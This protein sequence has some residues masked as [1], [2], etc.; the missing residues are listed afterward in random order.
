MSTRYD[1]NDVVEELDQISPKEL[2]ISRTSSLASSEEFLVGLKATMFRMTSG[3]PD[4]LIGLLKIGSDRILSLAADAAEALL[5]LDSLLGTAKV[6]P[7]TMDQSAIESI[8]DL[9]ESTKEGTYTRRTRALDEI[10]IQI[11]NLIQ[12]AERSGSFELFAKDPSEVRATILADL[13]VIED[14]LETIVPLQSS[15]IGLLSSNFNSGG[16]T[17]AVEDQADLIVR[18]LQDYSDKG[19]LNV[20]RSIIAAGVGLALMEE[21]VSVRNPLLPKYQ[22][23]VSVNDGAPAKLVSELSVPN[24]TGSS[25]VQNMEVDGIAGIIDAKPSLPPVMRVVPFTSYEV[26][27]GNHASLFTYAAGGKIKMV[28]DNTVLSGVAA[29]ITDLSDLATEIEDLDPVNISTSVVGDI[30]EIT[31]LNSYSNASRIA[32]FNSSS[33]GGGET[34]INVDFGLTFDR[35]GN[36]QGTD[37]EDIEVT[38]FTNNPIVEVEQTVFHRRE[39]D[40]PGL[41]G[42]KTTL[43]VPSS[44]SKPFNMVEVFPDD[45]N[46]IPGAKYYIEDDSGGVI[47]LDQEI[48]RPFD[49][50]TLSA[51]TS[52][53]VTFTVFKDAIAVSSPSAVYGETSVEVFSPNNFKFEALISTGVHDT[54]TLQDTLAEGSPVR[55]GD[56]IVDNTTIEALLGAVAGISGNSIVLQIFDT[57]LSTDDIKIYALGSFTYRGLAASFTDLVVE[58][59]TLPGVVDFRNKVGVV[60]SSGT[61]RYLVSEIV[62]KYLSFLTNIQVTHSQFSASIPSSLT[63]FLKRLAE[64]RLTVVQ[65]KLEDLDLT[66]FYALTTAELSDTETLTRLMDEMSDTLGGTEEIIEVYEDRTI[67]DRDFVP[68]TE[69]FEYPNNEEEIE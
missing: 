69:I 46:G 38:V 11:D 23:V 30:I 65:R 59:E 7:S 68:D 50:V 13:N 34:D 15:F 41:S 19:G 42:G 55:I 56:L 20:S 24:T 26:S 58:S 51:S 62:S 25:V 64:S 37:V 31:L 9:F 3:D 47:T 45:A 2:F 57:T 63:N 36:V 40:T 66:G 21:R 14:A 44:L 52:T 4:S 60:M 43:L 16:Y 54:I 18:R 10:R 32:F 28:I 27:P 39:A 1:T 29:A 22:G 67:F 53:P 33:P 49:G 6:A 8:I 48:L 35:Y 12:T 5:E 61:S 17:Y